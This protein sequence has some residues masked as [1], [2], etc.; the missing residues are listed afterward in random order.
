MPNG[1]GNQVATAPSETIRRGV[2]WLSDGEIYVDTRHLQR[3]MLELR[4][5]ISAD[6]PAIAAAHPISAS[7]NDD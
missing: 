7:L 5:A 2:T 3:A 6:I 1:R 4:C